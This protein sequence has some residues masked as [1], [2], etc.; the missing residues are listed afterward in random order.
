MAVIEVITLLIV[1]VTL[2]LYYVKEKFNYWK[3]MG[4]PHNPPSIPFG[5]IKGIG[6]KFHSH[7]IMRKNYDKFKTEGKPFC[8]MY[9]YTEPVVLATS[10]EFVKAVMV[11]DSH[12]F[13]NRGGYYNEKDDPL[14]G[15]FIGIQE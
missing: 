15:E 2:I 3:K 9:F 11:K 6:T 1:I 4:V 13:I 14:S 10:L 7:E 8:G 12:N 5:S